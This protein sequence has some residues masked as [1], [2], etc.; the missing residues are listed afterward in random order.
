MQFSVTWSLYSSPIVGINV[1]VGGKGR[2][3]VG[4]EAEDALVPTPFGGSSSAVKA[5]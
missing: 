2:V 1:F 5:F 3:S 4:C